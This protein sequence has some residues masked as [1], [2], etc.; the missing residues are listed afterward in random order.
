VLRAVAALV[1]AATAIALP[2]LSKSSLSDMGYWLD[3]ATLLGMAVGLG[4]AAA[5]LLWPLLARVPARSDSAQSQTP[6]P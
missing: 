5:V 1:S 4:V 6:R 3:W 2:S